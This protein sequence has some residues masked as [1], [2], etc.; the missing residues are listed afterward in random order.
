M[1]ITV[2]DLDI[3]VARKALNANGFGLVDLVDPY[4]SGTIYQ[5]RI[6]IAVDESG[7]PCRGECGTLTRDFG[8]TVSRYTLELSDFRV[9]TDRL[10]AL[11]SAVVSGE[12]R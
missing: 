11:L 5:S 8:S 9:P 10:V 6:W 4:E 1:K 12:A 3:R 7:T 2:T